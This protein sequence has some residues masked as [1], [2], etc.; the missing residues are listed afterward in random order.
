MNMPKRL[1][2]IGAIAAVVGSLASF[3]NASA[4]TILTEEQLQRISANCLSIKNTLNQLHATD[5]LLRVNRGQIYD[6]MGTKLMNNFNSR[7]TSNGKDAK[8]LQAVTSGYQTALDTF[9][10]DYREYESKLSIA[11]KVD[12]DKQPSEFHAAIED[13]RTKRTKLHTDV[14][15]LHQYIDDYRSGVSDFLINFE[16]TSGSKS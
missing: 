2:I 15:R 3:N 1:V 8:G 16:R 9:R 10:S 4:Q 14:L 11:I 6:A 13:A 5:A 12:C 7:L